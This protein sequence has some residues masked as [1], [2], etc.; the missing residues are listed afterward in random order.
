MESKRFTSVLLLLLII[1]FLLP[2]SSYADENVNKVV[3]QTAE[4]AVQQTMVAYFD[5][6]TR[7]AFS[8]TQT[9]MPLSIQSTAEEAV[10]QTMDVLSSQME[11]TAEPVSPEPTKGNRFLDAKKTLEAESSASLENS[12][13]IRSKDH[14]AIQLIP[15]GAFLMGSYDGDPDE[16]PEH[17]V[18]LESFWIDKTE[19]TNKQYAKCVQAGVC[20]RPQKSGSWT[21]N[22]YYDSAEYAYFPVIN[23]SWGQAVSYCKWVGGSLPTEA[24]WEKAARGTDGRVFPWGD[25]YIP[26]AANDKQS[27]GDTREV[28]SY[29]AGASPFGLMDMAGNVWEWTADWYADEYYYDSAYND[30]IGPAVGVN[31]VIRGNSWYYDEYTSRTTKRSKAYPDYFDSFLGFRCINWSM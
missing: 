6:S 25:E 29:P 9:A 19:V 21:R 28:G 18:F 30:P 11:K 22:N 5:L 3:Q 13:K 17:D 2:Q 31:R 12:S 14:A 20:T 15:E 1:P 27:F 7:E 16:A 8:Q 10:R 26:G 4:I 23:V 24:Q